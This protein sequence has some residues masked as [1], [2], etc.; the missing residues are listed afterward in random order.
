MALR[1]LLILALL[2]GNLVLV[3]SIALSDQGVFAYL[4][5]KARFERLQQEET[6]IE[7]RSLE[8]S[9]EIR[10]LAD[11]AEY[12]EERARTDMHYM[13][14]NEA[15]YVFEGQQADGA[16][17]VPGESPSE[18]PGESSQDSSGANANSSASPSPGASVASPDDN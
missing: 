11:D 7:R 12:I 4:E 6:D 14:E 13:G 2:A 16:V 15:L 17:D 8:L 3:Y 18:S 5:M 10:K 1:R 9:R